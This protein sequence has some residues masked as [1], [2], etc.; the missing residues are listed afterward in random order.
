[1]TVKCPTCRSDWDKQTRSKSNEC[2]GCRRIRGATQKGRCLA[3]LSQAKYRA[4]AERIEFDLDLIDIDIP[5][6]CP[7]L[8]IPLIFGQGKH[9]AGSPSV[10]RMEPSKGYVKGNVWVISRR[11]NV[12]KHDASFQEIEAIYFALKKRLS[13]QHG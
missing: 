3:L 8:G 2:I 7:M 4:K 9:V 12:I 10:D 13:A 11:A 6:V 1:M 5:E